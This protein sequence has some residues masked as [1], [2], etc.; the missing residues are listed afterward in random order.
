MQFVSDEICGLFSA[1][2]LS[3]EQYVSRE[4]VFFRRYV[5]YIGSL[6]MVGLALELA[7]GYWECL[8]KRNWKQKYILHRKSSH[9]S[10]KYWGV[11]DVIGFLFP[12]WVAFLLL[13]PEAAT[14]TRPACTQSIAE[15]SACSSKNV[16]DLTARSFWSWQTQSWF[17]LH[18]TRP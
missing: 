17:T 3:K 8:G 13:T 14:W 9:T 10:A 15:V 1:A 16:K 6:D 11:V 12:V 5:W 18:Q 7:S 4:R 2:N